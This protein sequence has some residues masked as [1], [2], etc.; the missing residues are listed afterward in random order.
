MP[1]TFFPHMPNETKPGP[2]LAANMPSGIGVSIPHQITWTDRP[3]L[4]RK[5]S[6]NHSVPVPWYSHDLHHEPNTPGYI[7]MVF[8]KLKNNHREAMRK[9]PG[10]HWFMG[11]EMEMAKGWSPVDMA[12]VSAEMLDL[13]CKVIGGGVSTK[14]IGRWM[15]DYLNAVKIFQGR[16]EEWA[17]FHCH[18]YDRERL[19][20]HS[21]VTR[22]VR[23]LK[24]NGLGH[25]PLIVSE[26]SAH[27]HPDDQTLDEQKRTLDECL[28]ALALVDQFKAFFWFSAYYQVGSNL[29][30]RSGELT[31]IGEYFVEVQ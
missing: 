14:Y 4:A 27:Q 25:L 19:G 6:K 20:M 29:I 30:D 17:A 18:I 5:L 24:K 28:E 7:P 11:N 26:V 1:S 3:A 2:V 21:Q 16:P 13:G 10:L 22:M 9:W 31:D 23:M 12:I 15:P 8:R